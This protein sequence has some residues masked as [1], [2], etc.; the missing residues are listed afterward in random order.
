[1]VSPFEL[2]QSVLQ[3][4]VEDFAAADPDPIEVPTRRYIADGEVAYDCAQLTVEVVRFVI[5]TPTQEYAGAARQGEVLSADL[6]VALIRDCAPIVSDDGVPSAAAIEEH[7]VQILLD[8]HRL[9]GTFLRHPKPEGCPR[10][11]VGAC[12]RY[13]PEGTVAGWVLSLRGSLV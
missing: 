9:A 2:A 6:Q 13:G 3:T 12:Q 11:K 4:V 10:V 7:A 1:M 5:G 8:G